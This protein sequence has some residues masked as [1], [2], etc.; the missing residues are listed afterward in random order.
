MRH[1][2]VTFI[3]DPVLSGDEVKSTAEHIQKELKDFGAT[4]VAVDEMGLRQLAYE[5]KRR[6]SGVYYCIE[7]SCEA[8]DWLAKFELNLK[9]NERLLRFLTV[10]LDKYGI[11][12]ND[13]KRSGRIGKKKKEEKVAVSAEAP[14]KP[15]VVDLDEEDDDE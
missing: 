3:V 1:Y 12:Y 7:F 9:R 13:D 4:I 10:K 15:V 2:E 14:P 11:K 6:S 5:M 8:A